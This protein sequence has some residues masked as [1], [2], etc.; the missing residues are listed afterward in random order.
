MKIFLPYFKN[1]FSNL[2]DSARAHVLSIHS[3]RSSFKFESNF[4]IT[5]GIAFTTL[6]LLLMGQ[7]ALADKFVPHYASIKSSEVNVRKGPT[8]RYSIEWV[9][10]KKGEPVEVIAKF[11]HWNRIRDVT[12]EEGWVRSVMLSKKRTGVIIVAPP[13]NSKKAT[14][15]KLFAKLYRKS[16]NSSNIFAHIES[17]KRVAIEECQKQWCK[18]KI[19][20][21]SGWIEK[22]YLWGVQAHEVFK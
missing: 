18:I 7:T 9:Y 11:E 13:K 1:Y 12:G 19:K 5:I 2:L 3:A 10:K 16:D 15:P 8:V 6:T 21:I 17:S 14:E 22:P 4:S 20:D